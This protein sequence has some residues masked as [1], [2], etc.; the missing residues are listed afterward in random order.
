M[1]S[2]VIAYDLGGDLGEMI[3]FDGS[4]PGWSQRRGPKQRVSACAPAKTRARG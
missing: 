1:I 2:A 4:L 3:A